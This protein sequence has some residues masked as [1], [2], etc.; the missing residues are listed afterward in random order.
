M[1]FYG[2]IC[3]Y[4]MRVNI[5]MAI[6]CMTPDNTEEDNTTELWWEQCPRQLEKDTDDEVTVL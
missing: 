2:G 1:G 6:V 4:V 5:S 3:L